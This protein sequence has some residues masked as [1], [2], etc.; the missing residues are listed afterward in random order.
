[1]SYINL[2][3]C[4]QV[5]STIP[6]Q[7]APLVSGKYCLDMSS[8]TNSSSVLTIVIPAIHSQVRGYIIA[9]IFNFVRYKLVLLLGADGQTIIMLHFPLQTELPLHQR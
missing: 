5:N 1:M 2:G 4:D 3:S 9:N 6:W 7:N 8:S